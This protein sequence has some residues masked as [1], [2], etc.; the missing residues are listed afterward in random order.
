MQRREHLQ[1]NTTTIFFLKTQNSNGHERIEYSL[2]GPPVLSYMLRQNFTG[3]GA[4]TESS[5]AEP[6]NTMREQKQVV[7]PVLDRQ[8]FE[9]YAGQ[10]LPVHPPF[11]HHS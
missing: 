5:H 6:E 10:A 1:Q 2:C 9:F 7:P 11:H 3:M 4:Q 8:Q